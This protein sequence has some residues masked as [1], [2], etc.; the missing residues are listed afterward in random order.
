MYFHFIKD[1][2]SRLLEC[3]DVEKMNNMGKHYP[4][5]NLLFMIADSQKFLDNVDL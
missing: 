5:K 2:V 3:Y 1:I 4:G